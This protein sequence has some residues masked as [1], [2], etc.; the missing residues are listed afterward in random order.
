MQKTQGNPYQFVLKRGKVP[1]G[2][3]KDSAEHAKVNLLTVETF[4]DTFGPNKKRKRPKFNHLDYDALLGDAE[5]R[6]G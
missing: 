6:G 2:L 3:L 1:Y 5:N 4:E